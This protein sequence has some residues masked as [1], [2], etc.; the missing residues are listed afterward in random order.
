MPKPAA[1]LP[2]LLAAGRSRQ[3][4]DGPWH[5]HGAPE[6]VLVREG[7][8][9]IEIGGQI[10]PGRRGTLFVLPP[11][12]PHA[13]RAPG[14]RETSYLVFLQPEPILDEAPRTF[15]VRADATLGRWFQDLFELNRS[16][17]GP[18]APVAA[19]LLFAVLNRIRALEERRHA[20]A[21]LHPVLERAVRHVEA[22]LAE[23]VPAQELASAAHASHGHLC[24]L[25]RKRFGCAPRAFQ[26]RLRLE[27][28]RALLADPYLSIKELAAQLG[29]EDVN[30]FVRL[31]KRRFGKPPGA[32]RERELKTIRRKA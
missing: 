30:Y 7:P 8:Y 2:E 29:F 18:V 9:A 14:W 3:R 16:A 25:F 26:I 31:F 17:R 32:W 6:I 22:R 20:E 4:G 1:F 27:R 24:R 19:G 21:G 12:I 11:H 5:A 10:L 13:V 23:Y 15:D 28:A